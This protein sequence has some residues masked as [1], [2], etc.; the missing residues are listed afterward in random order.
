MSD[1]HAPPTLTAGRIPDASGADEGWLRLEGASAGA[2]EGAGT[3]R[4]GGEWTLA[5]ATE[6]DRRSHAI[7]PQ[8]V[9]AIDLSAITR[10]DTAGAWLIHRT[11]AELRAA[12]REIEAAGAPVTVSMPDWG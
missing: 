4:F 12:G 7:D 2:G 1:A 6:L 8:A 9:A 3:L 10:M 11:V 5:T